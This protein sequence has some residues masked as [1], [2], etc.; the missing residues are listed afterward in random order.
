[1][2][3]VIMSGD[4][5]TRYNDDKSIQVFQKKALIQGLGN[6]DYL[7]SLLEEIIRLNGIIGVINC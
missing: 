6:S 5:E 7:I 3:K 1:M 2:E 4:Y